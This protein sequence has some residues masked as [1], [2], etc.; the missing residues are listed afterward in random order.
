MLT[1]TSIKKVMP[2]LFMTLLAITTLLLLIEL[3]PREDGIPHVD[4]AIHALIFLL[5]SALGY[6]SFPKHF[7]LTIVGLAFYGA[8][9]EALQ[10]LLTVT[11]HASLLDWLAD[12]TGILLGVLVIH[13]FEQKSKT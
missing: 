7:T 4:K 1:N 13:L 10:H 9:A 2:Y 12:I 5:L 8:L 11:R 3:A 6:L